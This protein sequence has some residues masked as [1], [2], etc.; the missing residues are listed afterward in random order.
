M[1][2]ALGGVILI[3]LFSSFLQVNLFKKL[4]AYA[5]SLTLRQGLRINK[6]NGVIDMK[7]LIRMAKGEWVHYKGK[8]LFHF[9]FASLLNG[10]QL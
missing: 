3:P 9:H 8:P 10:S 5:A 4:S 7:Q 1:K 6:S 2:T